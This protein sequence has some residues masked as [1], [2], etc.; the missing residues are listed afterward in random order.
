MKLHLTIIACA[1]GLMLC[2]ALHAQDASPAPSTS[3]TTSGWGGHRGG[4]GGGLTIDRLTQQLTLT[5]DQQTQ[6]KPILD[7]LRTDMQGVRADTTLSQTDR[8]SKMKDLRDAAFSQINALLTPD[9]QQKFTA[10]QQKMQR[11][12]R[13]GGGGGGGSDSSPAPSVSGS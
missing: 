4:G 2:P 11:G 7:K 6:I 10:M 1:A 9:Q 8:M 5:T 13:G 12:R 3:G